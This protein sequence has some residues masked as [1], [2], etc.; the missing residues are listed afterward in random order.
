[1]LCRKRDLSGTTKKVEAYIS[2]R[3]F[4]STLLEY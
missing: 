4:I 1:L 3:Q 2:I